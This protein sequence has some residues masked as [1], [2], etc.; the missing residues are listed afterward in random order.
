MAHA[1]QINIL[2]AL[3][4]SFGRS[5]INANAHLALQTAALRELGEELQVKVSGNDASKGYVIHN[6]INR[7]DTTASMSAEEHKTLSAHKDTLLVQADKAQPINIQI[8]NVEKGFLATQIPN[9]PSIGGGG[10]QFVMAYA[11]EKLGCPVT[12]SMK[13][14]SAAAVSS[15]QPI[16]AALAA[17]MAKALTQPVGDTHIA[18]DSSSSPKM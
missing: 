11:F 3:R 2:P 10:N 9:Q 12:T 7:E 8:D 5:E 1:A 6:A 4:S 13:A 14:A 18:N 16:A 17:S 15:P